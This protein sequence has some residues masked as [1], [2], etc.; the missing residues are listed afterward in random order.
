MND[1]DDW[2]RIGYIKKY[3]Y[4]ALAAIY[5]HTRESLEEDEQLAHGLAMCVGLIGEVA[6]HVTADF[7]AAYPH[8][9]WH[10]ALAGRNF[11]VDAYFNTANLNLL[12]QTA[13]ESIPALLE[14]LET[15][16]PPLGT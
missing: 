13:T 4:D 1:H 9:P 10:L 16:E 5:G 6:L 14:A 2:F 11:L 3:A 7:R 15:I 12:W 8:V